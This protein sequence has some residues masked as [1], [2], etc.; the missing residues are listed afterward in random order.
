MNMSEYTPDSQQMADIFALIGQASRLH[1][2]LAI[3]TEHA[4][5]C[6]LE[7]L[8]GLRQAYI[9]QQLMLLRD[10]GLVDT[11]R[12]G[13]HIFYRITDPRWLDLIKNA[14]GILGMEIPEYILPEISNCRYEP[15]E[16]SNPK[17]RDAH[18]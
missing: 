10:A 9:S 4:C 1:I 17:K 15:D 11:E 7:A 5:V 12:V 3:G 13:R 2:L 14:A 6:Q 18:E 8:L 16:K